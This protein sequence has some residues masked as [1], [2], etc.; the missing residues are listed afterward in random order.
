MYQGLQT[1]LWET[2]YTG[3]P[4]SLFYR[5]MWQPQNPSEQCIGVVTACVLYTWT[6]SYFKSLLCDLRDKFHREICH[7][8]KTSAPCLTSRGIPQLPIC[9]ANK[10]RICVVSVDPRSAAGK[11]II[12]AK[13]DGEDLR[14]SWL[15]LLFQWGSRLTCRGQRRQA[16]FLSVRECHVHQKVTAPVPPRV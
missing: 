13:R 9:I 14:R 3:S 4:G 7:L 16:E 1:R 11:C 5:L 12:F 10:F 8:T 2:S 6:A 15:A